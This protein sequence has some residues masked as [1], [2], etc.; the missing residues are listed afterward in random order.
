LLYDEIGE[1]FFGGGM[2]SRSFAEQLKALGPVEELTIR[3]N[4]PGGSVFEGLAMYN[5]LKGHPAARKIARVEG[6]AAS[7]ASFLLQAADDRQVAEASFVMVHRAWAMAVG[8]ADTMLSTAAQLEQDDAVLAGIYASRSG[9]KPEEFAALM[10][11]ETW[12]TGPEAIEAGLADRLIEFPAAAEEAAARFDSRVFSRFRRPPQPVLARFI[13]GVLQVAAMATTPP[14]RAEGRV[15]SG[16]N[17][18]RLERAQEL[19]QEVLDSSDPMTPGEDPEDPEDRK[20]GKAVVTQMEIEN[21]L[22]DLARLEAAC[23]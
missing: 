8:D 1:S 19:I 13:P 23:R 4:S 5:A 10:E 14:P 7:A 21:A 2:S 18:D 12:F 17:R 6:I 11:A 15:L 16:A 22:A 3:I 20:R 9:R